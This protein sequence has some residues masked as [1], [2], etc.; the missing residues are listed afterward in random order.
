MDG[1]LNELGVF[2]LG[3]SDAGL[4]VEGGNETDSGEGEL[5]EK[6]PETDRVRPWDEC[7]G[8]DNDWRICGAW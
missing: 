2:G 6:G 5:G 7:E 1:N 3:G 4:D 8:K